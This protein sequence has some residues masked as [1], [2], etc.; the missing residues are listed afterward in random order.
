MRILVF[1]ASGFIGSYITRNASIYGAEAIAL[2]RSGYI[3]GFS[4]Q[5]FRWELGQTLD[6]NSFGAIDCAIHL[7]HDFRGKV[8]AELTHRSTINCIDQL[9]AAGVKRQLFFSSYSAGPHAKSTYGS[10]KYAI[11][12][13]I[14]NKNDVI[15][16]RPGLVIGNGGLYGR[17]SKVATHLP[18]IPLPDGGKGKVPVISIDRLC[19]E[20]FSLIHASFPVSYANLFESKLRSL[21]QLVL[22]AASE[23]GKQP[24]IF[25]IPSHL[26]LIGLH[27]AEKLHIPL[28]VNA[29]N[30]TGFL[31]NQIASHNSTLLDDN[32]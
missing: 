16:V 11:E 20:T 27:A 15:T 28:P 23:K 10:T 19:R 21:R 13:E 29:D 17:I 6:Y 9:R 25:P 32:A 3:E 24:F 18:V 5:S 30:V 26:V 14:S 4:G 8:Q 31:A 1:G 22:E 12:E 2:C 7:A